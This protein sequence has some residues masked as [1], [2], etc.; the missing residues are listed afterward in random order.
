M[1]RYYGREYGAGGRVRIPNTGGIALGCNLLND[2]LHMK[3]VK[4]HVARGT[5]L[6]FAA[7]PEGG[8]DCTILTSSVGTYLLK[9]PAQ[10]GSR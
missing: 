7:I 8:R 5:K 4:N 10:V 2:V 1:A 9:Q 3:R 6:K